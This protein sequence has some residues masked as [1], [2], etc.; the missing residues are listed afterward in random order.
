MSVV[1]F[2]GTLKVTATV[3][4]AATA[5]AAPAGVVETTVGGATHAPAPSHAV[6]PLWLHVVPGF[7]GGFDGTPTAQRSSVHWRPSTGTSLSLFAVVVPPE[8]LHCTS[9][10]SPVS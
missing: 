3:V 7:S 5:V 6:P 10:Q 2:I 4:L 9:L 1:G 8:P